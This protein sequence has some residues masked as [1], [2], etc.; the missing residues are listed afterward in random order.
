MILVAVVVISLTQTL[1]IVLCRHPLDRQ[2][3]DVLQ[4]LPG[5]DMLAKNVLGRRAVLGSVLFAPRCRLVCSNLLCIGGCYLAKEL[6]V[7]DRDLVSDSWVNL[8]T[9][10]VSVSSSD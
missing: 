3:T 2:F 6:S 9:E 7:V 4:K 5:V 1:P 8:A 10:C